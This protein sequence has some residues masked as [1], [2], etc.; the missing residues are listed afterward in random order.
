L[1]VCWA[2]F[3]RATL[4]GDDWQWEGVRSAVRAFAAENPDAGELRF[5][6]KEN[7]WYFERAAV[8]AV[9]E[10]ASRK[11]RRVEFVAAT[12]TDNVM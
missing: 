4:V 1:A 7:W 10:S 11:Q 2:L 5:H 12:G 9:A 3:P 6:S 8:A